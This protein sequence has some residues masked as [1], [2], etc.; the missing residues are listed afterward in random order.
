MGS[1]L[2]LTNTQEMSETSKMTVKDDSILLMFAFDTLSSRGQK[3]RAVII[4]QPPILCSLVLLPIIL[5]YGCKAQCV[6]K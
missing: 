1:D 3:Q 4:K 6:G 2:T 5:Y